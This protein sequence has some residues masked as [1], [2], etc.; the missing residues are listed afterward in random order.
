MPF[1]YELIGKYLGY[2]VSINANIG[3]K[4]LSGNTEAPECD[5]SANMS[6]RKVRN[7]Y[8]SFQMMT[9]ENKLMQE[10]Q[11]YFLESELE[12][13][14]GRARLLRFDCTAFL[15]SN[16]PC[17]QAEIVQDDYLLDDMSRM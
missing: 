1:I 9:F 15:F 12:Q 17:R 16:Y 4:N 7:E 13:A 11:F 2:D 14:I 3:K 6:V 5:V 10:L 8:Y